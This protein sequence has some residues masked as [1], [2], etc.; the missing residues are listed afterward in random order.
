MQ[1]LDLQKV[2][3]SYAEELHEAARRVIDSG[4]YLQ[5]SEVEKFEEEYAR[6]I[7]TKFCRTCGNGLDALSLI[8]KAYI[9]L[10]VLSIGDEVIVPAN[11]FLATI[12]SITEN[13]LVPVFIEP[14]KDTL[15][16]DD[17]LIPQKISSRTR[18]VVIV[19]LYG[20]CS[21]TERVGELCKEHDL[22]LIEDNAQAHG[23]MYGTCH[24][25]SLGDA[26][27]HSFYP[28]KNLGALGDAGAVTT[29]DKLLA[30]TIHAI[31]NYGFSKKYYADY[32]GRNSRMDELQAA[33]LRVKL[34]HL[35]E[36]NAQRKFIAGIYHDN[37]CN[38]YVK[39]IK[40]CEQDCV[41]HIFTIFCNCRNELQ[42]FLSSHNIQ[43]LIHYPVPP[44]RQI[45]YKEY[46][47]I[48]LPLTEHLAETELS[49]PIS[50]V[51]TEAE[52]L[53]VAK[54]INEFIP[55]GNG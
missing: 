6:Y 37:I 31:A 22:L 24:T 42:E 30:D 12:L 38:P 19:H 32:V 26:A 18:A 53:E 29:N 1:F 41:F 28:G 3:A 40:P 27:A 8:F 5:G 4:W 44:H 11:T 16:I 13:G 17:R 48:S 20:T 46:S 50:P 35:D 7:G 54:V 49:L 2:N 47:N 34:Q 21:Y 51:M 9:Q 33:F 43:T 39:T 23:C 14:R 45:C 36:D 10:G 15:Q 55:K 52:A 25:G